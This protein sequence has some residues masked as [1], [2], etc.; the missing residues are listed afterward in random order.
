MTGANNLV[1]FT[2]ELEKHLD[3]YSTILYRSSRTVLVD[4]YKKRSVKQVLADI[5]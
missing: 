2:N 1:P 3:T 4:T 5:D